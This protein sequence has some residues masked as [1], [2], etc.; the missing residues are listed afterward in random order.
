MYTAL[1]GNRGRTIERMRTEHELKD[2]RWYDLYNYLLSRGY[3]KADAAFASTATV[4]SLSTA[5][6]LALSLR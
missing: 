6:I 4:F 5:T 3:S 1:M 2:L